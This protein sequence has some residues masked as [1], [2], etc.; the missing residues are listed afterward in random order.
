MV[1]CLIGGAIGALSGLALLGLLGVGEVSVSRLVEAGWQHLAGALLLL[2]SLPLAVVGGV[3]VQRGRARLGGSVVLLAPF[4]LSLV[5]AEL[6]AFVA[7]FWAPLLLAAAAA[8][9]AGPRRSVALT[10]SALLIWIWVAATGLGPGM[11][12][13]RLG[14]AVRSGDKVEVARLLAWGVDPDPDAADRTS[15]LR[16]AVEARDTDLAAVLL[17][18]GASP[19]RN[20]V[21]GISPL[22]RSLELGTTGITERMLIEQGV[23]PRAAEAGTEAAP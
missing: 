2:A 11:L 19:V 8:G 6:Q 7:A 18:H 14:D 21:D 16:Q 10:A 3:L 20:G 22:Q 12:E 1:L 23:F 13:S 17:A 4:A 15:A 5:D 9:L